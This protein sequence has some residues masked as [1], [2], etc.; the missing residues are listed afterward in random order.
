VASLVV[1]SRG[2]IRKVPAGVG[3]DARGLS[4]SRY[5]AVGLGHGEL[6]AQTVLAT[7]VVAN[8][9]VDFIMIFN[10]GRFWRHSS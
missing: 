2:S 4:L 3:T 5:F 9:Q 10:L 1:K 6:I 7:I 8:N